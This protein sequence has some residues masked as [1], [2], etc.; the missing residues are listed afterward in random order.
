MK[1]CPSRRSWVLG[2]KYDPTW[3]ASIVFT[4]LTSRHHEEPVFVPQGAPRPVKWSHRLLAMMH[5]WRSINRRNRCHKIAV[6]IQLQILH[7]SCILLSWIW[8]VW[9]LIGVL[10]WYQLCKLTWTKLWCSLFMFNMTWQFK[11]S[12]LWLVIELWII[13]LTAN[14]NKCNFWFLVSTCCLSQTYYVQR[15]EQLCVFYASGQTLINRAL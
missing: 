11:M 8:A 4:K 14:C 9:I 10:F 1:F 2:F 13:F 3:K 7:A 5:L 15:S 12:S 6:H